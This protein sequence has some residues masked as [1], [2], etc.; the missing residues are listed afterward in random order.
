[1][2]QQLQLVAWPSGT[3]HQNTRHLWSRK[4]LLMHMYN[5]YN[6]T[7]IRSKFREAY[8]KHTTGLGFN[9]VMELS[10]V[11]NTDNTKKK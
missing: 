9:L 10:S 1:M 8:K 4:A 6:V 3:R 5:K 2:R 7:A 11:D